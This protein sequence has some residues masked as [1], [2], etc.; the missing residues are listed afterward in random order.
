[1]AETLDRLALQHP[2]NATRLRDLG[3][4]AREHAALERQRLQHY[5]V[6]QARNGSAG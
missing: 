3:Q 1:V 6:T 4:A 5:L 2:H